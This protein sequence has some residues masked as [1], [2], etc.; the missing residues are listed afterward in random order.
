MT[1]ITWA[2][3][4]SRDR[5]GR[6]SQPRRRKG[7]KQLFYFKASSSESRGLRK[8]KKNG[9]LF[10]HPS[11]NRCKTVLATLLMLNKYRLISLSGDRKLKSPA[12][13]NISSRT[14]GLLTG[15]RKPLGPEEAQN[16]A[17]WIPHRLFKG[18]GLLVIQAGWSPE[19]QSWGRHSA[20]KSGWL[21]AFPH[22]R[23]SFLAQESSRSVGQKISQL[24]K[25]SRHF[26]GWVPNQDC[27]STRAGC[28][29]AVDLYSSLPG[30]GA[31]WKEPASVRS[32]GSSFKFRWYSKDPRSNRC[33]GGCASPRGEE[34]MLQRQW[35]GGRRKLCC[36]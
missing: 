20:E 2:N 5:K 32:L 16:A 33:P 1:V 26:P 29:R 3:T 6:H 34:E 11:Y 14:E 7:K 8:L 36:F 4:A 9:D 31:F 21:L 12:T 13:G 30:P 17:G 24:S 19:K 22:G 18:S 10:P 25:A 27:Q 15:A 35:L 28:Y 23:V